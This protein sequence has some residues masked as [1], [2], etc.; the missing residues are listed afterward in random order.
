M[1][2]ILHV[3][4]VLGCGGA[5]ILVGSICRSLVKKGHTVNIVY[6][7]PQHP[8]WNNYP[9]RE[10]LLKEV[11]VEFTGGIVKFRILG[12]TTS[13]NQVYI[14]YV[15]EF[16]PDIIHSHLYLAEL[17]SRSYIYPSATYVTHVHDNMP[18]LERFNWEFKS[19]SKQRIT[20]LWERRWLIDKYLKTQTSFIAISKDVEDYLYNNITGFKPRILYLPNAIDINRFGQKRVYKRNLKQGIKIV[21]IAN[22]VPKKNHII[23]LEIVEILLQWNIQVTIDV[24]GHGPLKAFLEEQ[25]ELRKLTNFI[26]FRGSVGEIPQKLALADLYLHP[27]LYEPFGLVLLE[28]MA[29]G[30][31]VVSM[32]GFGNRELIIDGENGYLLANRAPAIKF[33][34]KIRWLI[35][36]PDDYIAMGMAAR[37]FSEKYDIESY[38]EKLIQFYQELHDNAR[39]KGG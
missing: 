32:D 26:F 39:K 12:K 37:K 10:E 21:S 11:P 5:E 2:K 22:L 20:T 9:D 24:F 28:A 18:Q 1:M 34:E 17:L 4:P 7:L 36:H 19:I 6:L 38:T 15:N 3:I 16:K 25:V 14:D 27:A 23:L 29:S 31:P 8:S 33:A 13:D 30:L 35:E